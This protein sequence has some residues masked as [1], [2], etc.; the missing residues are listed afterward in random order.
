MKTSGQILF[1]LFCYFF[2]IDVV[3]KTFLHAIYYAIL[4]IFVV[5]AIQT[6]GEEEVF[7][8][9]DFFETGLVFIDYEVVDFGDGCV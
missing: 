1:L 2:E 6:V 3:L 8:V 5:D 4:I 9:I 7:V